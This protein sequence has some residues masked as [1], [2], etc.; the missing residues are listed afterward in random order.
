V[1]AY[2]MCSYEVHAMVALAQLDSD[3]RGT[4][5]LAPG[6]P[7]GQSRVGILF[8]TYMYLANLST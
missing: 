2:V 4:G 7:R 6:Y 3:W 1:V 8:F 5:L